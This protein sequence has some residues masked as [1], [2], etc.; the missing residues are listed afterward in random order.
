MAGEGASKYQ[1]IEVLEN[2]QGGLARSR[3][4]MLAKHSGNGKEAFAYPRRQRLRA[5]WHYSQV[6]GDTAL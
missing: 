1:R 4:I 3:L 6:G 5:I 2:G